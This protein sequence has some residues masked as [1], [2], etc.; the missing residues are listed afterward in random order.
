[1]QFGG[2]RRSFKVIK[3][4]ALL[5]KSGKVKGVNILGAHLE[6]PFLSD[7]RPGAMQPKDIVAP[8]VKAYKK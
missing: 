2:I 5:Q 1:M 4:V 8:S 3:E 6:R 7:L